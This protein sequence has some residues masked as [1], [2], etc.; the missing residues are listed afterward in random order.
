MP[1]SRRDFMRII[2]LGIVAAS[3]GCEVAG[4]EIDRGGVYKPEKGIERWIPSVCGQCPDGCGIL[5][6]VIGNRVVKIEGN[7]LHPLNR[8]GLCPRGQAGLQVLYDPDRIRSPLKRVGDRGSGKWREIGW[9]EA[10]GEVSRRLREIRE[11]GEADTITLISGTERGL[12]R[13][14]LDRFM[15]A[16]GSSSYI[17]ASDEVAPVDAI[18][19][20]Q[21]IKNEPFYDISNSNYI[22]NFGAPLLESSCQTLRQYGD[23]RRGNGRKRGRLIQIGPR[24]SATGIKADRWVPVRPGQEGEIALAIAHVIIKE[25]TFDRDFIS[26]YATGFDG[27]ARLLQNNYTPS[28]V[29]KNTGVSEDIIVNIAREFAHNRPSIAMCGRLR[30]SDQIAIH[31]L[32]ALSGS[33]NKTGGVL[34]G[35]ESSMEPLSEWI[36]K[37]PRQGLYKT[38]ALLLYRAN[39]LFDTPEMYDVLK[40]TPFVVSFSSFMDETTGMA[41]LIMP[42]N[43]YLESWG[44]IDV[45]TPDARVTG[46]MQPV[47]KPLYKTMHTGDV[48]LRIAGDGGFPLGPWRAFEDLLF[49]RLRHLYGRGS[50]FG[51]KKG[52][53]SAVPPSFDEF[54]KAL[55]GRGG[56]IT[57]KAIEGSKGFVFRADLLKGGVP[58]GD[59]AMHLHTYRP[60]SHSG[61]NDY[62]QPWLRESFTPEIPEMWETW[63]EVNP[64][65]AKRLGI[66]S[67]DMVWVESPTGRIRLKA[68]LY[69]GIHPDVVA[70]PSG[71]GEA[72]GGRWNRGIGVNPGRIL[73]REIDPVSHKGLWN[74]TGVKIYK[75]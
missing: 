26:R 36:G 73:T 64:V 35:Y 63:V 34:P 5:A 59:G 52:G 38:G 12:M 69:E 14:L 32:N 13:H 47:V 17:S 30:T 72:G 33:I 75:A 44:L 16:L 49:E 7:P 22:L 9:D 18:Y 31:C 23:F 1:I 21:G 29:S 45:L 53:N 60:L 28:R 10:I 11:K 4:R 51:E 56:L 70:V 68:R 50:V 71:L 27:F 37:G 74:Y 19:L 61:I 24:L 65:T 55:Q 39:P 25:G 54:I 41:D 48:I 67:A 8:G 40:D 66:S 46:L 6:R 57:P 43:T 3:S 42:D 20:T 15:E 62:N 58:P 2:G